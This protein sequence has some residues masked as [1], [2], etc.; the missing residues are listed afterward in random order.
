VLENIRHGKKIEDIVKECFLVIRR[1]VE[2]DSCPERRHDWR[3][4]GA[5]PAPRP[6]DGRAIGRSILVP[7]KPS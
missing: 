5:Q 6:N 3:S 1:V 4:G 2:M 7:E